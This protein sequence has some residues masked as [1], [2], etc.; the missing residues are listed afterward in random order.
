[1]KIK[2]HKRHLSRPEKSGFFLCYSTGDAAPAV[3][4]F[5]GFFW[6][7]TIREDIIHRCASDAVRRTNVSDKIAEKILDEVTEGC[8]ID[9]EDTI[10]P[11]YWCQLP[12]LIDIDFDDDSQATMESVSIAGTVAD[13]VARQVSIALSAQLTNTQA[14]WKKQ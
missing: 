9:P 3:L 5:D 8:G 12:D 1:M 11:D 6:F 14:P 4:F 2:W 7:D 13:I 10:P